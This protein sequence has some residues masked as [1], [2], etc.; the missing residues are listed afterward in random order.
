LARKRQV[1]SDDSHLDLIPLGRVDARAVSIVA[2]NL[3]T[4]M[5]LNAKVLP[6]LPDPET[7]YLPLRGQYAAGQILNALE[8]VAGGARFKLGIVQCDICTPIL[9]F[10]FGESQ[11]GGKTAVISL[12]RLGHQD[13]GRMYLRAA[14]IGLHETAHLLGIGH[15]RTPDC[16]MDSALNLEKLDALPLRFCRACDYEIARSLKQIFH[17][18]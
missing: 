18:G 14:K 16:L 11:L 4:V 6:P 9:K 13:P 1:S 8:S 2:A 15:C 7:A 3:Q 17:L 12:Y 10:V 5:G